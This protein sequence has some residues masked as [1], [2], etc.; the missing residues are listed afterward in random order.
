MKDLEN[1][2]LQTYTTCGKTI[3]HLFENIYLSGCAP[4]NL[5]QSCLDNNI[6]I[7]LSIG[8][9]LNDK[10]SIKDIIV[11][12]K[13]VNIGD[14]E[15]E[16]ISK[17]FKECND[18]LDRYKNKNILVHCASGMHRSPTI[19]LAYI[20]HNMRKDNQDKIPSVNKMLY[21]LR[22]K[23]CIINPYQEFIKQLKEYKL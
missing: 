8:V 16:N 5:R 22:S 17:Y 9:E 3:S 10:D 6:T 19:V 1:K 15:N 12:D 7:T 13:F 4:D 14:N 2:I 11:D 21:Y 18:Y 23:R 20:I